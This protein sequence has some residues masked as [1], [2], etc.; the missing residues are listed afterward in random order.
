MLYAELGRYTL[1]I[2]IKS[3]IIGLWNRFIHA[4]QSK[5]AY[6]LYF[7][8]KNNNNSDY[9]WISNIRKILNEVERNDSWVNQHA[10]ISSSLKFQVKQ[11]LYDQFLQ[12]WRASL[13]NSSKG[14]HYNIYKD[15][16]EMERYFVLLPKYI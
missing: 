9:K 7:V 16:V 4:K 15:T 12:N 1:E 8:L 13:N 10:I 14:R 2:L 3:L 6:I 5:I 11:I